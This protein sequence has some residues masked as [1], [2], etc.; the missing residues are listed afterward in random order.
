MKDIK[1][2][3]KML[4]MSNKDLK[5]LNNMRNRE[6][7]DDEIFGFHAQQAVEK[8]LKAWISLA[9]VEYKK[10]HNLDDLFQLLESHGH[11]IPDE[12]SDILFLTDFA[13][14]FRYD[15]I[16]DFDEELDRESII[17]TVTEI[18]EHVSKQCSL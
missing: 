17:Q 2:A 11:H 7:F 13:V 9:G 1:Y 14:T 4:L 6:A 12:F 3:N 8:A 15:T 18:I 16:D 10:T 5:A